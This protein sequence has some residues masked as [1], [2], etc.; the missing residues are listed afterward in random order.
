MP[1]W[2]RLMRK[3]RQLADRRRGSHYA[4]GETRKSMLIT[5]GE[6]RSGASSSR[7]AD[8]DRL[9]IGKNNQDY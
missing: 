4:R 6:H 2:R 8:A 9:I 7:S 1:S 5:A 3:C